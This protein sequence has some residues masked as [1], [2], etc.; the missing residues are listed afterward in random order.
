MLTSTF[1]HVQGIGYTTERKIWDMGARN[2]EQYLELHPTLSLSESKK[3]LILPR[4]EESIER[5]H[6]RDYEYFSRVLPSKDHWRA[7]GEF[8]NELAYL[9]I[10][11]TGCGFDDHITVIG[12]YDGNVMRAFVRGINLDEFPAAVSQYKMLVTFFGSGFDLPVIRRAFPSLELNQLHVDLCFALKRLGIG[13]GLKHIETRLGIVRRP[14]TEG[15]SGFDA[16]RLWYEYRRGSDDALR[17]L[18]EYNE[19]DVINMERLLS[20]TCG[21]L[22]K[23][24]LQ[25]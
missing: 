14:E 11:T 16:V 2:W 15:L 8:G 19:E 21:E 13:G 24:F 5:L 1:I 18:L 9:D 12:L 4:V 23:Q 20:Y 10:E 22:K 6:E 17:L 7:V 25:E 3:A